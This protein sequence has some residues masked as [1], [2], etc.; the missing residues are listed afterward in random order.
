MIGI[1]K[2][3]NKK[4]KK[5]YIGQSDNIERRLAEHKR[6]RSITID[7]YI[8]VLG[9]ENFEFEIL[10]E[11]TKEELDKKE[12][13]YIIQYN[14]QKNGYNIQQGGF[15]HSQG[16]G[17]GRAKLTVDD[18]IFIRQSYAKHTSPKQIYEE[19]FKDKITKSQFQGV[20]QGRSWKSVMPEVFTE[21][22]K[23][24]YISEQN[25]NKA[26]LTKDEVFQYRK[27]YITHTMKQTYELF[28]QEKGDLLKQ[29]T[30]EKIITG[31]V[32]SES[33]YKEVPV[34]KKKL[35]RWEL[36]NEPV[37]TIPETWE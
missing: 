10:E 22:N 3:T 34:Y 23:Q 7:D 31:D 8:N 12:Q 6:K 25:K 18:V 13:E 2:I 20:W 5:V 35:K 9:V 19:Y 29:R 28:K 14:S 4:N 21:E 24:Y 30:F 26:L 33:I 1:Y 11:C 32:R 15:N 37:S 17:N 27:Y 36:N 16:E